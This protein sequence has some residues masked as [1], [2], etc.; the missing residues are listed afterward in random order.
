MYKC[1]L[2]A[3]LFLF[4]V[5]ATA[6]EPVR[7]RHTQGELHAFLLVHGEDGKL[8]GTADEVN[9][10]V[11][12]AWRSRLTIHFLDGS[13]DDDTAT[14]T[15]APTLHLLADHHVQRGPT[16]PKPSDVA[17]D[18]ASGTVTFHDLSQG[19]PAAATEHMDLPADLGNGIMPLVLQN[20]PRGASDLKVSYL[21]NAPRPRLVKF[22]IHPDGTAAYRVGGAARQAAQYRLHV[23]IGGLEGMVAPLFGKEPPDMVA[24]LTTG[25]APTLLRL[26]MFLYLGG[27][28]LRLELA[29]PQW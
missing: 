8:L 28:M 24:W 23:D 16:F 26:R 25:D 21:V 18:T 4:L 1:L 15:Q 6:A 5:L 14:Y 22:A 19:A 11:G 29:S 10:A 13:V 17:L 2:Y 9:M 27:P 3:G 7:T 20:M 12:H